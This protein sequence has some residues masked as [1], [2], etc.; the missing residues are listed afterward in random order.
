MGA[1]V[2]Y[3]L[4]Y[5]MTALFVRRQFLASKVTVSLTWVIALLLLAV[6][7]AMPLSIRYTFIADAWNP[8][9]D[10][11]FLGNPFRVR[12]DVNLIYHITFAAI[13]AVVA[14]ILNGPWFIRQ[15][16]AFRPNPSPSLGPVRK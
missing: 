2:L 4:A 9:H 15:C 10:L 12:S 16:K 8:S 13:W 11:W 1:F 7:S 6:G 5:V 3:I 14:S